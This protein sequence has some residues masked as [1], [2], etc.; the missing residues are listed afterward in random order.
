MHTLVRFIGFLFVV[1]SCRSGTQ[2]P[3]TSDNGGAS[4]ATEGSRPSPPPGTPGSVPGS[5][6]ATSSGGPTPPPTPPPPA[7]P[8]SGPPALGAHALAFHRYHASAGSPISTP[9]TTT[10]A[11]GSVSTY[12]VSVGRGDITSFV[13]PTDNKNAVPFPQLGATHKYTNYQN[14]GTAIYALTSAAGGAGHVFSATKPPEDEATIAVVEVTNGGAIQDFKWNEPL[15]GNPQ[16]SLSVTTTGPATL[17]AFWWGDADSPGEKTAVPNNGFVVTDSILQAG[18][19]VQCA[20]AVKSV[21]A[22]GTY[23]VTWA[24]TPTQG[25]QLWLV[26]VQ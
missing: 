7:P 24:S 25:A 1:A 13:Q 15:A 3:G 10:R 11:A 19:L 22:A 14:S 18:A 20:A 8:A 2:S 21:S 12:V 4:G 16:T 17:V 9:A 23:D 26:A 6:G 5:S